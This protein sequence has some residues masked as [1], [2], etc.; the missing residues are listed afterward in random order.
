MPFKTVHAWNLIWSTIKQADLILEILDARNPNGTRSAQIEDFVKKEPNHYLILV[1]NKIDLVPRDVGRAWQEILKKEFP[2]I[3][4]NARH[5]GDVTTFIV[6]MKNILKQHPFW[7]DQD[8]TFTVL[9]VGYPNSGKSTLIQ[10]L[11]RNKKKVGISPLAG[12]TKVIQKIKLEEK[13]YVLD[14]PGIIPV[15]KYDEEVYQAL[16]TGSIR[17]Q[18]VA[19][20]ESVIDE[21][22]RRVGVEGLNKIYGIEASDEADFIEQLGKTRGL[23]AKGGIVKENEVFEILIRDWQRSFIA[24]YYA[25]NPANITS[26]GIPHAGR[27][28]H[29]TLREPESTDKN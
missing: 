14:S 6:F 10:S 12:F 7:K 20:K 1:L 13:L 18:L 15:E 16:D 5:P 11:T 25:P 8:K 19:D 17:P 23:L 3:A 28:M 29:A 26:K 9:V 24:F 27:P 21:I 22:F 4:I 2:T